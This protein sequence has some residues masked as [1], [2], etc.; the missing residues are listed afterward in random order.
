[1][2]IVNVETQTVDKLEQECTENI[3]EVKM[4]KITLAEHESKY[5]NMCKCS[6]HFTLHYLQCFKQTLELV[7]FLFTANT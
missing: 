2:K 5:E 4:V 6:W 1:M 7:L 3:D